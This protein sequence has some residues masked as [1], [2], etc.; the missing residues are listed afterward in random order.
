MINPAPAY[1]VDN[2]TARVDN[3]SAILTIWDQFPDNGSQ[4]P[5]GFLVRCSTTDN[6]SVAPTDNQSY[7]WDDS[8]GDGWGQV[9]LDNGSNDWM[10]DDLTLHQQ[11]FFAV[12]SFSNGGTPYINYFDGPAATDN[13]TTSNPQSSS[14]WDPLR[15]R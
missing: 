11:Y 5:N 1:N 13:K 6:V 4:A 9:T 3:G 10:W 2:F 12:Y 14:N 7:A 8:C 15:W